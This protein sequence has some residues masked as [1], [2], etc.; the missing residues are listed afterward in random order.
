MVNEY[1]QQ[2]LHMFRCVCMFRRC[3]AHVFIR[4]FQRCAA[5]VYVRYV[6]MHRRRARPAAFVARK[7]VR[8]YGHSLIL[9]LSR[10]HVHHTL[11]CVFQLVKQR[12]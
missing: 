11:T 10:T 6:F 5:Y 9:F 2:Q 3:R 4:P 1:V 8:T 7:Y 12:I